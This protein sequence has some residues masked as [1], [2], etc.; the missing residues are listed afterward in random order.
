MCHC[1]HWSAGRAGAGESCCQAHCQESISGSEEG[2]QIQ[3]MHMRKGRREASPATVPRASGV[4]VL[5]SRVPSFQLLRQPSH[6]SVQACI[7]TI[8]TAHLGNTPAERACRHMCQ[9]WSNFQQSCWGMAQQLRLKL[10]SFALAPL[11]P[12]VCSDCRCKLAASGHATRL[13]PSSP[14]SDAAV[15]TFRPKL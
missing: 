7:A 14:L 8:A 11:E 12:Q 1:R 9:E 13:H 15:V 2:T 5:G 4:P 10:P 3:G 6:L